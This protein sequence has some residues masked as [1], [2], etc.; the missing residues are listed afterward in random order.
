[1]LVHAAVV[2]RNPSATRR[3]QCGRVLGLLIEARGGWVPAPALAA[4]SLQYCSRIFSLRRAGLAIE[5][6]VEIRDGIKRGYFRLRGGVPARKAV[7][8]AENLQQGSP[9]EA[10]P[11]APAAEAPASLFGNIAPSP[12]YPD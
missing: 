10:A 1:M 5:N 12:E 9:I 8:P 11:A 2:N 7:T 3:N 6:K 4:V